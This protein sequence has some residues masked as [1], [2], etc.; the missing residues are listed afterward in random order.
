MYI[1]FKECKKEEIELTRKAE[2]TS[3]ADLIISGGD[4]ESEVASLLVPFALPALLRLTLDVPH[5]QTAS[6]LPGQ[7][8]CK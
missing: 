2:L 4:P 3:K 1:K 8:A 6:L 7:Q 5:S